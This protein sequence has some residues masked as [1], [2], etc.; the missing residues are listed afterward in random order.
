MYKYQNI[1]RVKKISK[2]DF[3]NNYYKLQKPI[4]IEEITY[5]W[6]AYKKWNFSYIK[7]IAGENIVPLYDNSPI[8]YSRKVNE[9]ITTMKMK[10]YISILEKKPTNLRIFLYNLIKNVPILKHDFLIPDLGVK[11]IKEFPML[12]FGG[13]NAKVFMHYDIDLANIFHFHFNGEKKCILFPISDRKNMYKIPY[14]VICHESINFENIDFKKW[15][16]LKNT[17]GYM[18]NLSHG[19]MLYIPEGWWHQM[20]YI[21]PG[22]SMS[23]RS[24]PSKIK[25]ILEALYNIFIS[26]YIDNFMRKWKKQNWILYKNNKAIINTNKK[27]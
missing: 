16:A 14:S 17:Q 10:E 18:T 22:F 19:E 12:F 11:I 8:N 20:K 15:P 1:T 24:L 21:T 2:K 26:R 7:E 3:Y 5:N 27:L 9:C 4:V 13:T 23:L 6:P 25:H